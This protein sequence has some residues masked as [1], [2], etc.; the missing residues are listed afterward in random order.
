MTDTVLA[1]LILLPLALTYFLK[2][3]AGL[4]FLAVCT[5]FVVQS[6]AGSDIQSTLDN[7]NLKIS[8]ADITLILLLVPL[9]LTFFFSSRSWAGQ[10]K[11]IINAIAA[12]ATGGLLA[13]MAV[14]YLGSL[15]DLNLSSSKVWSLVQHIRGT[16]IF[17]GAI[18][19]LLVVWFSK[20]KHPDKKHK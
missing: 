7:A 6:L 15:I 12:L 8:S 13:I 4:G 3:N 11:M 17:S 18:Y 19:S 9:V 14:P 5:G 10:S 20:T 2:A 1:V 16:L